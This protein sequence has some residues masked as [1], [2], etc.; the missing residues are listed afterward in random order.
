[1]TEFGAHCLE[2]LSEAHRTGE[3]IEIQDGGKPYATVQPTPKGEVD[4][5]PGAFK[6]T[7]RIVGDLDDLG[8]E[9]EALR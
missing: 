3:S 1:M 4:W 8:V 5:T 7:T 6:N 2:L 9:W